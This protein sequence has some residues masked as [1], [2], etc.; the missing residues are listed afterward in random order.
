MVDPL[1]CFR[2][3]ICFEA[4]S[5]ESQLSVS[6]RQ[7]CARQ[8]DHTGLGPSLFFIFTFASQSQYHL[9]NHRPGPVRFAH[10]DVD[11]CKLS[12]P[13][14]HAICNRTS[15]VIA[16]CDHSMCREYN[17]HVFLFRVART[18]VVALLPHCPNGH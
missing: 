2:V 6:F 1:T 13:N 14:D 7:S 12:V 9:A 4:D 15:C 16:D 11:A 5:N 10:M 17:R 18:K 8:V 3:P